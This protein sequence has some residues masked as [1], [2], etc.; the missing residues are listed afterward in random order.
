MNA[1][2]LVSILLGLLIIATRGPLIFAPEGTQRVF[3]SMIETPAR[4]RVLGCFLLLIGLG[5]LG[6]AS[7]GYGTLSTVISVIGWFMLGGGVFVLILPAVYQRFAQSVLEAFDAS[8]LRVLGVLGVGIGALF[9]YFG[10]A[11]A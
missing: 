4:V 2:A 9:V 10:A 8:T 3:L 7:G 6:G 5:A 11:A 1:L